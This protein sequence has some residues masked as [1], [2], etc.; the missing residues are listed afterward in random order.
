MLSDKVSTC[1]FRSH[2]R[3]GSN[4][5]GRKGSLESERF[6]G[7]GKVP[8]SRKCHPTSLFLPGRLH[9]QGSLAGYSHGAI[10]SQTQLSTVEHRHTHRTKKYCYSLSLS[11]SSQYLI[12]HFIIF[13]DI[14]YF[15]HL[16]VARY[17]YRRQWVEVRYAA[18]LLTLC[19]TAPNDKE[20]S[21]PKY[22]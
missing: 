10:K 13:E 2:K 17:Y 16:I 3:H 9:E 12:A 15:P 22:Q 4:P 14:F 5:W 20:L 8:W 1:H 7:V 19:R 11:S 21:G 6:P 18:K